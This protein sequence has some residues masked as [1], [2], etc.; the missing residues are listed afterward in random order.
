MRKV[1]AER[2]KSSVGSIALFIVMLFVS[3][4][5]AQSDLRILYTPLVLELAGER[6]TSVPFEITFL[7]E[8]RFSTAHF[9]ASVVG[10]SES[11]TGV[12]NLRMVD[13]WEHG[14]SSWVELEETEFTISPGEFYVLR[15]IVRIPRQAPASGYATVVTVLIPDEAPEDVAASTA[16]YQQ[17]PVALEITVGQSHRRSAFISELRAIPTASAPELAAAYGPNGLLFIASLENDGDVHIR[18]K[19]QLIIRDE[20]GRRVRSVP[21]GTGRGVIIPQATLDFGSVIRGLPPGTY[22]VEAR[23]EYGGHRPAVARTTLEID[24]EAAGALEI[25]GG[26]AMRV[27]VTPSRIELALQR[28]G[29][30]AATVTV[31]NHDTVDVRFKIYVEELLHDF[32]G[33]PV[34][35]EPGVVLPYSAA[36]WAQV[37]P[38]EFVLRPGQRRNV[39]IGFQVPE[40]ADGG[41]Y[42]RIRIQAEPVAAEHDAESSTVITDLDVSA[43]LT[44]GSEHVRSVEVG[45][46][47][48]EQIPN[49]PLVRTGLL[50]HNTGNIHFPVAGRATLL[51]YVPA[52]EETIGDLIVQHEERW[53]VVEQIPA[54][55]SG[56]PALPG[57]SRFMQFAWGTPFEPLTQYQVNMDV[58]VPGIPTQTYRLDLWMDADGIVHLGTMPEG[59]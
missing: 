39:V 56:E 44:V 55:V 46:L 7:N 29:Y 52:V 10:L 47:Q 8:A 27:D 43:L 45:E 49:T 28:Q 16:Y 51:R 24:P 33:I 31:S 54:E 36:A 34:T 50:V 12:Y 42:A 18:G 25:V 40:V 57:E 17:F 59:D 4:V 26:R 23:I 14:A 1:A 21:L 30:R 22:E 3:P 11:R 38:D 2:K 19:G 35:V 15:G 5:G 37:R 9:R 41:R 48:W 20:Q 6:G 58:M 53:D 13:D 32:D